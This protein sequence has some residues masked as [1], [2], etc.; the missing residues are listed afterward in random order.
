M[1]ISRVSRLERQPENALGY[2]YI[3]GEERRYF[4][5]EISIIKRRV[6]DIFSAIVDIDTF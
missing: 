1:L 3:E 6:Y 4:S 2:N 5:V